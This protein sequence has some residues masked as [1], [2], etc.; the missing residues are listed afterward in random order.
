MIDKPTV[1]DDASSLM[2]PKECRQRK[3]TYTGRLTVQLSWWID[4]VLQLPLERS[5]GQVPIMVIFYVHLIFIDQF[6]STFNY[7]SG[8]KHVTWL[9]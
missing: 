5:L 2:Y 1:G 7:R 6:T 4:D 9:A 8:Q 3:I